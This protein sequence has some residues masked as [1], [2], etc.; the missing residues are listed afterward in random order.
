MYWMIKVVHKTGNMPLLTHICMRMS[1]SRVTKTVPMLPGKIY[2]EYNQMSPFERELAVGLREA[3][4]S[5]SRIA[6]NF[7]HCGITIQ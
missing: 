1:L 3:W 4:S 7:H 2:E 6:R 5:N